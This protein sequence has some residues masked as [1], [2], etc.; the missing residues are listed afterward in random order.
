MNPTRR[1]L[2]I[3]W[4]CGL[5]L[6]ALLHLAPA[7]AAGAGIT[8]GVP[9]WPSV[10][11]TANIIKQI[12]EGRFGVRVELQTASNPVI[13]EAMAKG[14]MQIHPEVW[15]PNQQ[16]LYERYAGSVV[17]NAHPA[18]GK[19]GICANGAAL[20]SGI[21]DVSDLTDPDKTVLLDSDADGRGEIFIGAPGWSSTLVE[22]NR[23][24]Q[25]GY[26]LTLS[27]IEIDEGLAESQLSIAERRGRPWVGFCY[28][29][30]HRFILH[31]DLKMLTEPPYQA[32]RWRVPDD[33]AME[34]PPQS[35]QPMYAKELAQRMPDAARLM[36][37]MDLDSDD[38]SHFAYEVVV[39]KKDAAEYARQWI[40]ANPDRI[41]AWFK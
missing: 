8:I 13:F 41:A 1:V 40:A 27:T 23:A 18:W 2:R 34:W 14:S 32:A 9:N 16:P 11:V 4:P 20:R 33:V 22:R 10:S 17:K 7:Q 3:A 30:H 37:N 24:H 26:D 15:L 39:N 5:L 28:T 35:I 25:Y 36:A 19:Q 21:R 29:P 12:L 31:P 6:L 38:I